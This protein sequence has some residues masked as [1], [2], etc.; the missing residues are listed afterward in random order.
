M[1]NRCIFLKISFSF[2]FLLVDRFLAMVSLEEQ[3]NV[4]FMNSQYED[5]K[6]LIDRLQTKLL[7]EVESLDLSIDDLNDT[8]EYLK[9]RGGFNS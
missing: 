1:L 6:E 4:V 3:E 9:D 7:D 2:P 8:K 5:N